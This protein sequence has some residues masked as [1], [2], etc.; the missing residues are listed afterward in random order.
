MFLCGES[1][2]SRNFCSNAMKLSKSGCFF[3]TFSLPWETMGAILLK[4]VYVFLLAESSSPLSA[5]PS[6][7]WWGSLAVKGLCCSNAVSSR[8]FSCTTPSGGGVNF[9]CTFIGGGE[10]TCQSAYT[11]SIFC[12]YPYITGWLIYNI[13]V[14]IAVE[15]TFGWPWG[16]VYPDGATWV[17]TEEC[18][19]CPSGTMYIYWLASVFC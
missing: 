8:T 2:F 18:W 13:F 7:Y 6:W 16:D 3:R 19:D 11:Y 9:T 17:R 15:I 10:A 14:F 5:R 1:S 4:M 12:F